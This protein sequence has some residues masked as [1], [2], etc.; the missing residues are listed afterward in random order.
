MAA[1]GVS[2][3]V[4]DWVGLGVTGT[5]SVAV[6][7]DV[8]VAEGVQVGVGVGVEVA[9]GVG[10]AVNVGVPNTRCW[11]KVGDLPMARMATSPMTSAQAPTASTLKAL[12]PVGRL[13]LLPSDMLVPGS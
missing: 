11:A 6:G 5:D 9:V 4:R 3:G 2:V 7:V 1:I 8:A 10:V 13:A 12:A